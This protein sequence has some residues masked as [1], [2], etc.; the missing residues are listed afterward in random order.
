[1]C[2]AVQP[3]GRAAKLSGKRGGNVHGHLLPSNCSA[4]RAG[5]PWIVGVVY[6][7]AARVGG[8]PPAVL[9]GAGEFSP[10]AGSR[11][12]G[13][14]RRN[15]V[16]RVT[17]AAGPY[18]RRRD[19]G[20]APPSPRRGNAAD[21]PAPPVTRRARGDC[22]RMLRRSSSAMEEH[23]SPPRSLPA[24]RKPH[25]RDPPHFSDRLLAVGGDHCGREARLHAHRRLLKRRATRSVTI[26]SARAEVQAPRIVALRRGRHNGGT[27]RGGGTL[28]PCPFCAFGA[29]GQLVWPPSRRARLADGRG[30]V[31]DT[32]A[33]Y[34]LPSRGPKQS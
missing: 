9:D 25:A 5:R 3:S 12:L 15:G 6:G 30:V 31:L 34:A 29:G 19:D 27:L 22:G 26:R 17:G 1:V 32:L 10:R 24:A 11:R 14:C 21:G 16:G 7:V 28:R 33:R 23:R 20:D 18:A 8:G 13:A 4:G 2:G